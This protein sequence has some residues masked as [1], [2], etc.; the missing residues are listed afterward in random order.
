MGDERKKKMDPSEI[1]KLHKS[2]ILVLKLQTVCDNFLL[3]RYMAVY[4]KIA[5]TVHSTY[6]RTLLQ[7]DLSVTKGLLDADYF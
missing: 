4:S 1:Q 5:S 3:I 2:T 7:T 6:A